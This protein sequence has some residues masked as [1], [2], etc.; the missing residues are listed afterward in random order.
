M[1]LNTEITSRIWYEYEK[2]TVY[3]ER[4]ALSWY[5]H[6]DYKESQD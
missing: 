3:L 2:E 6:H 4:T 5:G 1:C